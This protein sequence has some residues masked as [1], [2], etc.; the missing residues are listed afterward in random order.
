[1]KRFS[2]LEPILDEEGQELPIEETI[3]EEDNI[4]FD[5]GVSAG[6]TEGM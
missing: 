4:F 3:T 6:F 2:D 1:L 5:N